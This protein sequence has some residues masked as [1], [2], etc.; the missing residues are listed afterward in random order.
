MT[1]LS[2]TEAREHL[3]DYADKVAFKGERVCIKRN[4]KPVFAMVSVEDMQLLE[5]IEDKIDIAEALKAIRRNKFT[6]W[7]Q[8][9][10]KLGL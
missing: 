4:G 5:A 2:I 6:S 10:K 3:S 9:K 8:A 1:D 7:K